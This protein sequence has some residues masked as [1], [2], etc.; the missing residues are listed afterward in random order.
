MASLDE[1]PMNPYY[2]SIDSTPLFIMLAAK[3]VAW[4]GDMELI[5]E[6]RPNIEAAL[7]W[8]EDR[9]NA[10][11]AG[12]LSYSKRSSKGLINQ[13]WKDSHDGIVNR[14]GSF[15]RPP[16]ALAEV[17]GYVYAAHR[18][19][20]YLYALLGHEALAR[21]HRR[22]ASAFKARFNRDFWME[23][24]RFYALASGG[25]KQLA[26]SITSNPGQCLWTG[27]VDGDKAPL[28]VERLLS[29]DMFSGWGIRTLSDR[30][31]RYNPLGYHLGTVWP[32]DNSLIG[33]G[34]KRYGFD[35]ELG[36]LATAMYD[37]CRSFDYYRLPELF[38]G[39]ARTTH[40]PPVG[41]PVAARPQAWAAGTIAF[42]LSAILGLAPNAPKHELRLVR[43]KLP[44]WLDSVELRGLRIGDDTVDL[45]YEQRQGRTKVTV[46]SADRVKVIRT[47][48]WPTSSFL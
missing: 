23:E 26:A 25:D 19:V 31:N 6:I 8:L 17:Q 39:V 3:Y 4:T 28:V 27:I 36:D 48:V 29:N 24:Q 32:H 11:P 43:P 16:I 44:H 38:S 15:V 21:E 12:Y 30:A 33:M 22:K 37:A 34:F 9:C 2:G 45:Y 46:T 40:G 10:D 7:R 20:A 1:I 5:R 18:G 42:F 13:G 35:D 14:N 41:Y 47:N